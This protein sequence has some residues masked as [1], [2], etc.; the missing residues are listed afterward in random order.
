MPRGRAKG[1]K[2]P[3]LETAKARVSQLKTGLRNK[4]VKHQRDIELQIEK[5]KNAE[6]LLEEL[7]STSA[8]EA[9]K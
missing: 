3:E 4:A 9:D 6:A 7:E 1:T 2:R 8:K 5:I